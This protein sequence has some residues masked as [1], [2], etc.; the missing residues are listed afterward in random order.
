MFASGTDPK[1][2]QKWGTAGGHDG[3]V[4]CGEHVDEDGSEAKKAVLC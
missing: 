4:D 1:E 3:D 2:G